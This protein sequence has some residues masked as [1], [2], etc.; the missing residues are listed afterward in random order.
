MTGSVPP[1]TPP[2]DAHYGPADLTLTPVGEAPALRADAARNRTR[3]LEA[4]FELMGSCGAAALTMEAVATSAGVGKGTVF[5]R[6]GDRTGLLIALLDHREE[7]FQGAFLSGPPPLGPDAPALERLHA[8]G[9]ATVRHDRDHHELILA[10][11]TD[12]RRNHTVPA[13][14]LRLTHVTMLLRQ[15]HTDGDAV[16][17][18]HTLLGYLDT[19]LVHHLICE[20][21]MPVE[22]LEAGW[23]DLVHRMVPEPV[24]PPG[25]A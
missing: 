16:L 18:A 24:A 14:R 8:F 25:S 2:A 15:A 4:A 12:P 23:H 9:P 11:R 3:L 20:Q 22:R 19:A 17:L 1:L 10:A 6:F 5:R 21:S 13:A 7:L